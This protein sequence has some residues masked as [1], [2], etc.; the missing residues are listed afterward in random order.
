MYLSEENVHCTVHCAR[1]PGL[2]TL[3]TS[4]HNHH[5]IQSTLQAAGVP[6]AAA[7]GAGSTSLMGAQYGSGGRGHTSAHSRPPRHGDCSVIA[8][9]ME[10][11]V[12][13][14][15]ALMVTPA[16][17]L[18]HHTAEERW[19]DMDDRRIMRGP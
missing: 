18:H 11:L 4:G 3:F 2:R 14:M 7:R 16:L 1:S 9:V 12:T 19:G 10:T 6:P 8:M 15:V 5:Y 17:T 13:V